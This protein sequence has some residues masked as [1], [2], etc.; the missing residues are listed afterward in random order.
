MFDFHVHSNFSPDSEMK[1][2]DAVNA[3]VEKGIKEMCFTDHID[4]DYN[5]DGASLLF[6]YK[7]YFSTIKNLQEEFRH[8]ISIKIGVE[9]GLQP[10]IL[11]QC[12]ED[13]LNN[14]FD[15]VIGSIHSVEK[16]DLYLGSFFKEKDQRMAYAT[17]FDELNYVIDHFDAYSV[18]GH[19][20]II[21]RYGDYDMPLPLEEFKEST[22]KIF[23]KIIEKGKG[24]ELNTSGI[25]YNLG[26]YHP[27]LDIIKLYHELGG[28]IITLGSDAHTPQ[29]VSFDLHNGLKS[30]KELGFKYV[31][32]FK[33][34]NPIFHP[35][36]K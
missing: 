7:E 29:Q 24:I 36:D 25:R 2:E 8:K 14:K 6:D 15:F 16:S 1:M 32:T 10:H 31:A 21:K 28:E 13:V 18:L 3:A 22:G 19:L 17:Y 26:D 12:K 5:G 11:N 20:D 34:M 4:Y 23:K 33:E 30:L 35:I 27:S 9:M